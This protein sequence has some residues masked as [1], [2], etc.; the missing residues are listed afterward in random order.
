MAA[1]VGIPREIKEHEGRVAIAP[2]GVHVLSQAGQ[3]VLIESGAGKGSGIAN[4]EFSQAGAEIVER[5]EVFSRSD[6]IVKVKEPLEEEFDLLRAGQIVFTFFHFAASRQLLEAMLQREITCVAYETI[7]DRSGNLPILT[8]MSEVA[9]RMASS[10]DPGISRAPPAAA[11]FSS[12]VCPVWNR[13][14]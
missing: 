9:G 12:P 1:V 2:A 10:K 3:Q 13:Q 11:G 8:P 4:E 14:K 5:E 6:I 7:R